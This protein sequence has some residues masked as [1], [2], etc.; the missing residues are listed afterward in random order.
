[1]DDET[2]AAF[3]G[4]EISGLSGLSQCS[5]GAISTGT[6]AAR[7]TRS[8][9]DGEVISQLVSECGDVSAVSEGEEAPQGRKRRRVGAIGEA[10]SVPD[11]SLQ[12]DST[13]DSPDVVSPSDEVTAEFVP[14]VVIESAVEIEAAV[15]D[16]IPVAEAANSGAAAPAA[17]LVATTKEPDAEPSTP[18]SPAVDT[19]RPAASG[20]SDMRDSMAGAAL[21]ALAVDA[22]TPQS[23]HTSLSGVPHIQRQESSPL[24]LY[25]LMRNPSRF[26][27]DAWPTFKPEPPA[28]AAQNCAEGAGDIAASHAADAARLGQAECDSEAPAS[29]GTVDDSKV[30]KPESNPDEG[31][32]APADVSNGFVVTPTLAGRRGYVELKVSHVS[33]RGWK[34]LTDRH[35]SSGQAPVISKKPVV[36]PWK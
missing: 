19:V 30:L 26:M 9:S 12:P 2:L 4:S 8:S 5:E 1:M 22:L 18:E 17:G 6:T 32:K 31:A 3:A 20:V 29:Q 23:D 16:A 35:Q 27:Q 36:K 10:M 13:T 34:F 11:P 33:E 28:T 25:G 14:A 24:Q 15:S 7:L 21:A